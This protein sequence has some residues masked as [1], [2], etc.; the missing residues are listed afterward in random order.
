MTTFEHLPA[1]WIDA[2]MKAATD[3]GL[4]RSSTQDALL[5]T[6]PPSYTALF[7]DLPVPWDRLLFTLQTLD[8]EERLADG[9]V[10]FEVWLRA[11]AA[12]SASLP[13]GRVFAEAL[14]L[15]AR[16]MSGRPAPP[17]PAALPEVRNKEAIVH[18]DD[19]LPFGFLDGGVAAG[20]AVARLTVPRVEGGRRRILTNGNEDLYCGTGWLV[21]GDLLVTNHH[22]VNARRERQP[23]A[24]EADLRAQAQGTR[25]EFDVD[26][27]LALGTRAEVAELLV[28]NAEPRL[29]YAILRLAP[30]FSRPPLALRREP[31]EVRP[32]GGARM[33]VNIIQH[34]GGKAKK[35]A[36]RNNLVSG[37]SEKE[38]RYFTDTDQGSSGS[39]VCD[40]GWRVV[41]L[42]S[43][44]VLARGVSFQGREAAVVNCGVLI[45]AILADLEARRGE[46]GAAAVLRGIAG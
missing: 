33:A 26:A 5:A 7:P 39:P 27:E 46:A 16:N 20:R 31:L 6:L 11:A 29:D 23:P 28:W 8:R 25:V 3:T 12:R 45:S 30:P 2:L 42:H 32:D 22:V 9:T 17:D 13:A 35:V 41:A 43:S 19:M 40:D 18:E 15:V 38:L 14:E 44:A 21:T 36:C 4:L 34:P 10:P 37:I 1:G 24:A